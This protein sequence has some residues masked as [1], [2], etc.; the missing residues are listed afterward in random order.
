MTNQKKI[1]AASQ[2]TPAT[3]KKRKEVKVKVRRSEN[4]LCVGSE[5]WYD[6]FWLKMMFIGAAFVGARN[7]RKADKWTLAY[8]DNGY[9]YL[10]K[11]ALDVLAKEKGF[12]TLAVGSS[13][14]L[15]ALFNR[16]R[17]NFGLLDVMFFCH[18]ENSKISMNY[19][20]RPNIDLSLSN[21][22]SI[23]ANAFL[24]NGRISSYA[25]RTGVLMGREKFENESDAQPENSLAQ[26]LASH[27]NIE[28]HA[29][30]RR[31]FYGNVLRVPS[32]SESISK[33]VR[34]GKEVREGQVIPVPP[35]H[36][37]LPHPG[38][39]DSLN[40]LSGPKR[41]GTDGYALWRKAGG[42]TLPTAA[43]TP[44]GLSTSM[45]IFRPVTK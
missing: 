14:A 4:L 40:P 33:A 3:N 37:A 26:R 45:R 19:W 6:S 9:T 43:Q 30:L 27:L 32:Q 34:D 41:E 28:V 22:I 7:M 8:V 18:G 11:L 42:I 21:L 24:P 13:S 20:R 10:E 15:L 31:T 5:M 29:Y 44:A 23:S 36:E 12:E 2:M 16:D 1:V 17:D 38:L 25:C 35:E 39:A